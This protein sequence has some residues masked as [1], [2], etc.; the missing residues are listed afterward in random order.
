ME[1][2]TALVRP[3]SGVELYTVSTIDLNFALVILPYHTELYDS[4]W[5]GSDLQGGLV[6]GVFLEEGGVFEGRD[7]L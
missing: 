2:E 1:A 5:D 7:E 3:Q 6:L 4:L